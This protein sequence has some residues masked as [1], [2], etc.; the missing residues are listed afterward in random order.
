MCVK[1]IE[2]SPDRNDAIFAVYATGSYSFQQIV[3]QFGVHF[4]TVGRVVRQGGGW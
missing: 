2:R 3:R 4:T 1:L